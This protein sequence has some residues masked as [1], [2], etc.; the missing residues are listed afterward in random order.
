[1]T[2]KITV[3]TYRR[4]LSQLT[5][6]FMEGTKFSCTFINQNNI[7]LMFEN[8]TRVLAFRSRSPVA[9]YIKKIV[10]GAVPVLGRFSR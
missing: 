4:C 2:P 6:I 5:H 8:V 9:Y 10:R 7:N 1:M 3:M